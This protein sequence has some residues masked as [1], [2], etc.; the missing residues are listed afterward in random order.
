MACTLVITAAFGFQFIF[1]IALS[2]RFKISKFIFFSYRE[3][4][5]NSEVLKAQMSPTSIGHATSPVLNHNNA[6]SK[7]KGK[8]FNFKLFLKH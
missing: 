4:G 8:L 7:E 6:F 3:F 2:V 5:R 1:F